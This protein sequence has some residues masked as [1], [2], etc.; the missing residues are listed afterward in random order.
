MSL[1]KSDWRALRQPAPRGPIWELKD[2][3]TVSRA[4]QERGAPWVWSL[5]GHY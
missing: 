2:T 1:R 5:E 3:G 4:S